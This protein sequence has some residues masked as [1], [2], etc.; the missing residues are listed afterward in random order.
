MNTLDMAHIAQPA[1]ANA[2]SKSIQI[3]MANRGCFFFV[4][5]V[6]VVVVVVAAA[7]AMVAAA[8]V[9]ALDKSRE[10]GVNVASEL[11]QQP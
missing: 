8:V 6:F 10:S 9:A 4:V 11:Q 3:E 5:V 7:A 1:A 2:L